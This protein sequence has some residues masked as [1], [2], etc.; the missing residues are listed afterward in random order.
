MRKPMVVILLVI[1]LALALASTVSAQSG[2]AAGSCPRGFELHPFMHHDDEHE[3]EHVH[4]G[5]DRDLNQDG[6]ICVRHLTPTI[7]LHID[8]LLPLR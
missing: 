7:H 8:N 5:L 2:T 3:P 1:L 4:I 6:F